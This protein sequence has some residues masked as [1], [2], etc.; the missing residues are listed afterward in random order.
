MSQSSVPSN[1]NL[2]QDDSKKIVRAQDDS[3]KNSA[4][5]SEKN[6]RILVQ[7]ES[8]KNESAKNASVLVQDGSEKNVREH[9]SIQDFGLLVALIKTL[10]TTIEGLNLRL[11]AFEREKKS[12]QENENVTNK[13][14]KALNLKILELERGDLPSVQGKSKNLKDNEK[15]TD[16]QNVQKT[17]HENQN[18]P[19][20][21]EIS[22]LK[23][24]SG[25]HGTVHEKFKSNENENVHVSIS[26]N[27]AK[28][29]SIMN[30]GGFNTTLAEYLLI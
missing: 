26:N 5:G 1:L 19:E 18:L 14:I 11:E 22:K 4:N 10:Q 21:S 28:F 8:A 27:A 16:V 12:A 20:T 15:S 2:V 25:S 7:D 6:V 29:A 24:K 13:V 9:Q 30:A 23:T 17:V 3:V